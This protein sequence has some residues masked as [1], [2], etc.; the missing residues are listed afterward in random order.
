M[1]RKRA[2][3]VAEPA[4]GFNEFQHALIAGPELPRPRP[5]LSSRHVDPVTHILLGASVGYAAFHRRLGRT[6]AFAGGLAA[7][8]PDADVFIRS[9][10]DPLLAI[11][12]HRGFTH[13][14]AFA[15][16]GAAVV[17][18]LWLLRPAW[19]TRARWLPLWLC[20]TLA[21]LSHALLDA[22][23]TY[24]TQLLWPFSTLRTGWDVI[25]IID[26]IFTLTLLV[27]LVVA[28]VRQRPKAADLGLAL[29]ALYI[30]FG[31]TQ[32]YRARLTLRAV[33]AAR[34]HA[35]ERM[36]LMP[37][38]ANNLVWRALYLHRGH[39]Y[40][41]RVRVGWFSA[42]TVRPGWS[43]P[44]VQQSD[45][46]APE[47]ARNRLR[48]FERFAWFSDH[49]VA[50]SPADPSLL[51]DMRYTLSAEAFDPIWGIRFTPPAAPTEV[52][53]VNRSRER[54]VRPGEMWAEII[55]RDARFG[56]IYV[57]DMSDRSGQP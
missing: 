23:T 37:T 1:K 14:L 40:S 6:A 42:P 3:T 52:T 55:G 31:V 41:D 22:A 44:L 11:E 13:A 20:C 51:A 43:L 30:G 18:A 4:A 25:A 5:G 27:A 39:I 8:A 47:V 9:A 2:P 28:L 16:V 17:A 45:L 57:R 29:A 33:A 24:G 10:A 35:I 56:S 38:L 15:P 21:Y 34:G 50:R 7:F 53:W 36:E 54:Q 46:T 49:W 48:S 19:R 32:Y 12:H 26:P